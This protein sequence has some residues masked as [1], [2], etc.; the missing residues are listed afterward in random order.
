M[1]I[2]AIHNFLD[3]Y[4]GAE[5]AFL[6]MVLGL[7]KKGHGI[8]VL[9][10]N[11]SEYFRRELEQNNIKIC[12]LN[13]K[14]WHTPYL[15]TLAK[16]LSN[17]KV[18]Y[19]F[20][21]FIKKYQQ[22]YDLAFVHHFY[23]TPLALLFLNIPKI[24]FCH[25]PPRAY[26]EPNISIYQ[27]GLTK[28]LNIL[29]FS[30]ERILDRY[31]VRQADMIIANSDYTREYIYRVYGVL[32]KTNH[33]GVDTEEFKKIE[34]VKKE[35]IVLSVGSLHPM[36]AHDFVIRSLSLVSKNIRPKLVICG[37][38]SALEKEKMLNLAQGLDVELELRHIADNRE[39]AELYNKAIF[40]AAASI[41]E[42]F[43]LSAIESMSCQTPVIAVRE[44]GFGETV[45]EDTGILVDRDQEASACAMRYLI[46]NPEIARDMGRRGRERVE[47]N[48][49]WQR[50]VEQLEKD[51]LTLI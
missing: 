17:I 1:K 10:L 35:N 39:M 40:T 4:G 11:I 43:G 34:D 37:R 26:Y 41:M 51:M 31:C 5:I 14:Q 47:T 45:T 19:L 13:F 7:K 49:S 9:V 2:L 6:N 29:I 44:G 32:A 36:K 15:N 22:N 27:R 42:P 16:L 46:Q 30:L 25:E 3:N 18:A 38:G 24:Y 50:N 33:L 23:F 28:P 48:F 21:G 20:F 12:S 8:D